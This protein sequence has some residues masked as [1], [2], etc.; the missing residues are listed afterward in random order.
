MAAFLMV[1]L[2]VYVFFRIRHPV[3]KNSESLHIFPESDT[4]WSK[5]VRVYMFSQNP[6]LY[7]QKQ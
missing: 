2:V 3:V 4:L 6:T 7:G 5:T 1:W